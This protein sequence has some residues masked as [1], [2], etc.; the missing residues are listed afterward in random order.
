VAYVEQPLPADDLDALAAVAGGAVPVA[1]D[2]SLAEHPLSAVLAAGAADVA[3][4]KPMALGGPARTAAAA[5]QAVEAGVQP[6]VTTTV[7]AVHARTAAVHVAAALPDPPACGLATAGMLAA[8]LAT[9]PCP[10]EDGAVAV[11][12]GPGN[13]G[14]VA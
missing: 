13:L 9:D 2:E 3:V 5:R 14:G 10:V 1:V 11:P 7:D 6:V 12:E 4:L 8:D